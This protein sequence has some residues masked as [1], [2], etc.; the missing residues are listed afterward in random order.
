MRKLIP[1]LLLAGCAG[2]PP[3][4]PDV[5]YRQIPEAFLQACP[6]PPLPTTNGEMEDAFVQTYQCA[7]IGNADK[8]RIKELTTRHPLQQ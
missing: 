2:G 6:L 5:I 1:L 7:Q 3:P 8:A 4:Q